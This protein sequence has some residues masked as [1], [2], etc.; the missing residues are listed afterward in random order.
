MPGWVG[1]GRLMFAALTGIGLSAAAGLNAY[2]PFLVVALLDRFTT[3]VDLPAGY[4]W[5]SS[6]WAIGIGAVLLAA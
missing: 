3:V 4:A 1:Y 5:M 2:I 6:W